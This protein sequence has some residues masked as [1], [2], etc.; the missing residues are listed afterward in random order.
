[1][2]LATLALHDFR[3]F[4]HKTLTLAPTVNI[5]VGPNASGKTSILE[6]IYLLGHG[7]S[8]RTPRLDQVRRHG[9]PVARVNAEVD[10]GGQRYAVAV[11]KT[12]TARCLTV[13]R[14]TERSAA[15]LARLLPT[16]LIAPESHHR[17][18]EQTAE[19]RAVLGWGLFHVEPGYHQLW[20]RYL[21]L[22]QQRTTALQTGVDR[23]LDAWEAELGSL[24]TVLQEHQLGYLDRLRHGLTEWGDRLGLAGVDLVPRPGFPPDTALAEL[25]VRHRV[26]DRRAGF[27]H[28]GPHRTD[29]ELSIDTVPLRQVGSHG[30]RK[31][32]VIALRL[33]QLAHSPAT[34]LVDDLGAELD[35]RAQQ[36]V[37][38]SLEESGSQVVLTALSLRG[39]EA[40]RMF[41]VELPD[42]AA[43]HPKP[44]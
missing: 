15:R 24:G 12:V 42:P 40:P 2:A 14:Q 44:R 23:T 25:L 33:A 6:A 1:M 22:L 20:Q 34:V 43:Q 41:H 30:Q 10:V 8:F 17:F 3:V 21:R 7:R 29:L 37:L 9:T 39:L 18:F 32:A 11:E 4:E 5:V 35:E 38:D 36:R 19:R 26:D 31:L 27:T 16:L 13:D 28:D